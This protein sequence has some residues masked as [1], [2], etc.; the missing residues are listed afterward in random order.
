MIIKPRI[1]GFVC[2]TAHPIGCKKNVENQIKYVEEHGTI[3]NSPKKVLVIGSSTGYGL[4]SRIVASFGCQADTIGVYFE[5]PPADGKLASAGYYNAQALDKFS[6]QE[7]RVSESINGDAFSDEIKQQTISLIKEKLG[8]VDAVIYSL[9][10][11]RRTDPD[12]GET[13]KS[14]LKPIGQTFNSKTINT[15]TEQIYDISIDPATD[16]EIAATEKV[17]GGEDWIRWITQLQ[18]ADVLSEGVKTCA[19]SYIGPEITFPIYTQG[20][21]GRAKEDLEKAVAVIAQKLSVLHGSAHLSVNKAVVTQ[22]SSAIPVVPLY[23]SILFAVMKKRGNHE[24]CIEQMYRLFSS[25]FVCNQ[26]E[27]GRTR[28]DNFELSPEVQADVMSIWEQINTENL[29]KI[30]DFAGYRSEFLKLFGFDVEGV[31][32]NQEVEV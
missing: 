11:P 6:H 18:S 10:S 31:D 2:V 24:G 5:R 22:A 9:A 20:T 14:V 13:F 1:K 3:A 17:M 12:T 8:K 16:D 15:D 26:D 27:R 32:Y 28:L 29:Y 4:A 19:Y 30:S 23:I 7:G 25:K 21:I